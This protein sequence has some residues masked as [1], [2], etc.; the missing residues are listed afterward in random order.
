MCI[1]I[2]NTVFPLIINRLLLLPGSVGASRRRDG[3]LTTSRGWMLCAHLGKEPIA[4]AFL[5]STGCLDWMRREKRYSHEMREVWQVGVKIING[6]IIGFIK[7]YDARLQ[8][9]GIDLHFNYGNEEGKHTVIRLLNIW[10]FFANS[11]F[12]LL[13]FCISVECWYCLL[14]KNFVG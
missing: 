14:Q 13:I 12:K 5:D 11:N 9:L 2:S 3:P 10:Y 1:F 4:P 7:I 6:K 8:P